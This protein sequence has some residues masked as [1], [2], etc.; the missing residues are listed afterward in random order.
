[1]MTMVFHTM[2]L[3]FY[4]NRCITTPFYYLDDIVEVLVSVRNRLSYSS[5]VGSPSLSTSFPVDSTGNPKSTRGTTDEGVVDNE[6]TAEKQQY[7]YMIG[8]ES[9]SKEVRNNY[10][11]LMRMNIRL[12]KNMCLKFLKEGVI[13]HVVFMIFFT[14]LLSF[15]VLN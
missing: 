4:L 12:L 10:N 2:S 9:V 7:A 8:K 1:M 14:L 5:P 11:T 15:F 3:Q 6:N 13:K